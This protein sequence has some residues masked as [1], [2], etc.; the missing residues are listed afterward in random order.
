[1]SCHF[2]NKTL[3]SFCIRR[4]FIQDLIQLCVIFLWA[5]NIYSALQCTRQKRKLRPGIEKQFFQHHT[6]SN[7][8]LCK[9]QITPKVSSLRQFIISQFLVHQESG[10][11]S[12]GPL[13][14]GF[15]LTWGQAPFP[16]F[17]YVVLAEFRPLSL[18]EGGLQFIAC[19][20]LEVSLSP[21]SHGAFHHVVC[22]IK[23]G[24]TVSLLAKWKSQTF[25]TPSKSDPQHLFHIP[26]VRSKSVG[27]A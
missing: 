3:S 17:I 27:P 4:F 5:T 12:L 22:F 13:L 8:Y 1:M 25:V 23:T 14:Q 18:L 16:G 11:T 9:Y 7:S 15:K 6:D 2:Q 10:G 26:L 20:C 21:L 19:W 24:K